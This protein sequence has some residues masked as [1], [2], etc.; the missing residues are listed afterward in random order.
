M[1][2]VLRFKI[3]K[4]LGGTGLDF[5]IQVQLLNMPF[6]ILNHSQ[7]TPKLVLAYGLSE[8]VGFLQLPWHGNREA[9]LV[10][11]TLG[12][13]YDLVRSLRGVVIFLAYISKRTVLNRFRNLLRPSKNVEEIVRCGNISL[14]VATRNRQIAA[15]SRRNQDHCNVVGKV[16]SKNTTNISH[17]RGGAGEEGE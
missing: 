1:L 3:T 6:F 17:R 14:S 12:L 9:R 4:K 15:H 5:E 16:E 7:I 10:E 11:S 2:N 13:L 8:L